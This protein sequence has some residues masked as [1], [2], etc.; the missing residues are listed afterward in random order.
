VKDRATNCVRAA[1]VSDTDADTLQRFIENRVHDD[2]TVYTDEHRTYRGMSYFR[3]DTVRHSRGE[4]V[5]GQVRTQGIEGFWSRKLS[6]L[7]CPLDRPLDRA[8]K[9]HLDNT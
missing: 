1:V 3:H 7:R 8:I 5:R 9:W 6:I 2:A 4:Y